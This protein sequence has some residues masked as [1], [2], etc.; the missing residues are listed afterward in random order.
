MRSVSTLS[1]DQKLALIHRETRLRLTIE[2]LNYNGVLYT[3]NLP[4]IV[5]TGKTIDRSA[6]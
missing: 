3:Q 1:E 2:Y 5:K 4:P 6:F